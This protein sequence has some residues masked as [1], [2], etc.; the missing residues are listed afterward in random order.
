MRPTA[1][2]RTLSR[3]AKSVKLF[4]KFELAVLRSLKSRLPSPSKSS[5]WVVDLDIA[6]P[7]V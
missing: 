7:I 4:Q 5:K 3:K 2:S 6:F 1:T